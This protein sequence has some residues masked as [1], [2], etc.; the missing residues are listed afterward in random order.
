MKLATS[1]ESLQ[2]S[3]EVLLPISSLL[4]RE[5]SIIDVNILKSLTNS[6]SGLITVLSNN[7]EVQIERAIISALISELFLQIVNPQRD[8]FEKADLLDF[9]VLGRGLRSLFQICQTKE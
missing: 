6:G 9:P 4:P 2:N 7:K 5:A 8:L 3:D 1:L